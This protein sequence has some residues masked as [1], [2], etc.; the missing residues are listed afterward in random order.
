MLDFACASPGD[1]MR[2]MEGGDSLFAVDSQGAFPSWRAHPASAWGLG[3]YHP[4]LGWFVL[5]LLTARAICGAK[6]TLPSPY[7]IHGGAARSEGG[8]IRGR[9]VGGGLQKRKARG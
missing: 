7:Q 4:G 8:G 6:L 3:V 2:N 9:H 5:R 1:A